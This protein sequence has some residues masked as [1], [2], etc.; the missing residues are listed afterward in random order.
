MIAL[1]EALKSGCKV[2]ENPQ[3]VE[4]ARKLDERKAIREELKAEIL[5]EMR[6]QARKDIAAEKAANSKGGQQAKA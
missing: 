6:D 1:D 5:A 4:A 2:E 3:L